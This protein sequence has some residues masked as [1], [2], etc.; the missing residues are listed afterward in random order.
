MTSLKNYDISQ[1]LEIDDKILYFGLLRAQL[2]SHELLLMFYNGLSEYG[3][4]KMKP[5]LEEYH[6][7]KS[8]PYREV[9]HVRH[10]DYYKDRA[11]GGDMPWRN[12]KI[13]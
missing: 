4:S 11:Y 6:L 10:F 8:L 9:L 12:E 3:Y 1:K 13:I 5:L 2:S 7:L